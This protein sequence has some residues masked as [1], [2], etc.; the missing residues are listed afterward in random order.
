MIRNDY[1][2]GVRNDNG[3]VDFPRMKEGGLDAEF[4]V[5]FIG[6]GPRND[7]AFSYVN[8]GLMRHSEL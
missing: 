2:L 5:V 1:D 3:C 8:R 7:S 4:F 6:Q